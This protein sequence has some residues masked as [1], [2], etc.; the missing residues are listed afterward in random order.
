MNKSMTFETFASFL[1]A[2]IGAEA[3]EDSDHRLVPAASVSGLSGISGPGGG[4][5]VPVE[6]AAALWTRVYATGR[7]LARCDRQ[8]IT[9]GDKLL[10]PAISE[11]DRGDA[12]QPV[13]SRFGGARMYWTDQGGDANDSSLKFDLLELELKKLLGMFFTTDEL[14]EDAPALAAALIRIFGLEAAFGIERAIVAGSGV[15]EPL[16]ILKAPGLLTVPKDAGQAAGTI[17]T[18]NLAGMAAGLWGPSHATAI[19]MMGNDAYGQ[20]VALEETT[21]TKLFETGPNGE[22]RLLQMPVELCE[23]TAPLGSVGDVVLADMS[24]YIVAEK[25]QASGGVLSSIHAKFVTDEMAF[26]LR[27]RVDGAPAWKTPITP[28]NSTNQQ[29][30]FVALGAR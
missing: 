21:G 9:K 16:G 1:A 11:A 5:L 8:P 25:E 13:N 24:Q 29:S 3:A 14:N 20:I 6:F 10:I 7:I 30:A 15:G 12:E 22:R 23:Y 26:K 27:Y 19:W 28:R 18:G 17:T 4:F 2:V